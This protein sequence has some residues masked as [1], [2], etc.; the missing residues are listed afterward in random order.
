[1]G[2]YFGT[3]LLLDL[4]GDDD[5]GAARYGI[6][7]SA[8]YG[9]GLF[10]DRHGDDRYRSSGPFYTGGVAWDHGVS[11]AVDS[12]L[13]GEQYVFDQS[14]G[15]G[16]ADFAGW[17]IFVD[18]GGSDAYAVKSGLGEASEQSLAAF[19][20]LGGKDKYQVSAGP[21]ESRSADGVRIHRPSGGLFVDR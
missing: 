13:G 21:P 1:M 2:Y 19:F 15:L 4:D 16:K 6:G 20:D 11:M 3:G 17:A 14:T 8:H 7:A 12:G 5:Y 9:V 18:E 10:I